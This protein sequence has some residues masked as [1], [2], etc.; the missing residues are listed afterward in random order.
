MIPQMIHKRKQEDIRLAHIQ[1]RKISVQWK[2]GTVSLRKVNGRGKDLD[3]SFLQ[4][5]LK[6]DQKGEI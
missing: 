5:W 2:N 4:L 1:T 3:K 6:K